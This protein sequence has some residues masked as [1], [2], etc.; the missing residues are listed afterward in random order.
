[1]QKSKNSN[2]KDYFGLTPEQS[3]LKKLAEYDKEN[4]LFSEIEKEASQHPYE[5]NTINIAIFTHYIIDALYKMPMENSYLGRLDYDFDLEDLKIYYSM[6]YLYYTIINRKRRNYDK[7]VNPSPKQ[8]NDVI[9]NKNN[10]P[11]F[12]NDMRYCYGE[13]YSWWES[14]EI[15]TVIEELENKWKSAKKCEINKRRKVY[16][17]HKKLQ[18]SLERSKTHDDLFNVELWV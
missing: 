12:I 3:A 14:K 9:T 15:M 4:N 6:E 5:N 10:D 17:E 16:W 13:E 2:F 18:L 11:K 1:M 8:F 7:Y